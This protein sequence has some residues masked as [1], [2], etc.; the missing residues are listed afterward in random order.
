[1]A[2]GLTSCTVTTTVKS[3]L[4]EVLDLT[5]P[6]EPLNLALQM[7]LANGTG[8]EKGNQHWLDKRTLGNG[9]SENLDLYGILENFRGQTVNFKIVRAVILVNRTEDISLE[10]G[11]AAS[12]AWHPMFKNSSDVGIVFPA[13]TNYPGYVILTAPDD[14]GMPIGAASADILKIA[15]GGEGSADL[16]YDI[17]I[18]GEV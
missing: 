10:Y 16:V 17:V 6:N 9:D 3:T 5:T 12:N 11:G 4:S 1:M 14:A 8:A 7:K 13:S 15:H 2:V 18:I